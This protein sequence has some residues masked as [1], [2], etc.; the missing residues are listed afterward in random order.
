MKWWYRPLKKK[1]SDGK[2]YWY[3]CEYYSPVGLYSEPKIPIADSKEE[4]IEQLELML[5]NIKTSKPI[6][7]K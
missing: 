1:A 3:V 2:Y 6:I 7:D 4:L 5:R